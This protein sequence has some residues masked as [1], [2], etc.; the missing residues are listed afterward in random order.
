MEKVYEELDEVKAELEKLR[1]EYKSKSELYE[2][3]RKAHNEQL[4]KF[5]QASSKIE[6]QT[7]ELNKKT[8]EISMAQQTCEDLKCALKEEESIVQHLRAANDKLRVDCDEKFRKLEDTNKALALALDEANEKKMDQEQTLCAYKDEI[9]D[10]KGRLSVSQKKCSEA[11]KKAN[12]P[13]E[14]RERDE[15]ILKL[16]EE[17]HKVQD[18]IKWKTE[19][20][21]HLEEAHD[22]LRE[23]FKAGKKEWEME[24]SSFL[25]EI[26]Q[27]QMSLDSK[28]QISDNL[29]NRLQGCNQ[30][31]A[32]EESRTKYL[33]VQVSEFQTRFENVFSDRE[34]AKSQLECL[35]AQRD[36][37]IASLRQSLSTKEALHKEMGYQTRKLEQENQEL[38]ALLKE[39]Q[40]AQIQSAPGS[41][42]L[43]K[44][45]NK[46]KSLE[47][48]HRESVANHRAKEAEW[49]S[50]L[51]SMTAD[52][53]NHKSELKS[54][55][56]A[57]KELRMEVEQKHRDC[58][59]NRLNKV[60]CN[61]QLEKM[62]SDVRNYMNEL[63]RKDATIEELEMELE[64]NHFLSMQELSVML[65]VLKLGISGAQLKIANE[66]CEMDRHDKENE[67]KISLLMQQLEMK[68]DVLIRALAGTEEEHEKAASLSSRIE[69]M[70]LI[71]NQKLHIRKEVERELR[72]VN[73]ALERSNVELAE[74]I[75][76]ENEIEFELQIWK[77]I[78]ERLRSDLEAS[79]GMCKEL[80]ASLLAQVEVEETIK[81][82]KKG[83]L[84]IFE[85][86]DKIIDNLQ[87]KI[88]LLE[89]KLDDAE[90]VKTE[91][92]MSL[93]SENSIFLQFTREKDKNFEQLEK[94]VH[95]LE[96]ESLRREFAG[97]VMA[98]TDAERTFEYEK[99]KL[100]QHVEEKYQR[101]NVLLQ[102]V[103][104]LEHKFNSSLASF[105]SQLAEK[106]SEID[107]IYEAWEKITA[108]EVMAALEI[109]EKQLMAMELEDEICNIQQKLESQQ[110]SSCE[111]KQKALEVE[112]QLET[113]EQEVKRLTNQMKTK[114][115]NSDPLVEELKNKRRN[116]LEDVIQLSSEKENLLRFIGGLGD[117][118]W[119]FCATDKQLMGML[120][121]IM[122]S[123]DDKGSGMD[124]KWDD[125]LVDPEQEN[126]RT[127][128]I[129]KISEA[130]SDKR[131]P[132]RDLNH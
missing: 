88:V 131:S 60:V 85:E 30:A 56:A 48:M 66:K 23:Q 101:V 93:E 73:D 105:S 46:L 32:H 109:E 51:E 13:K 53:N 18:K 119:E 78:A 6:Q 125:E 15:V 80:E 95:W 111:S 41:P 97:L 106:Q 8:E 9:K 128:I 26:C 31:L 38:R 40:E 116:L 14:P 84:S 96:Q 86:K 20:F 43:A 91:T 127:P 90:S 110:K 98:Q 100:I 3:L 55:G 68:N 94:E 115:I 132:F 22:K 113:K 42:S 37:Q 34:H 129:V 107:M 59:D 5:Q 29:Q 58:T 120:E 25:D 81:Q 103:E 45:R 7:Q 76:E 75:F 126:V 4:T 35:T 123:F 50:Q 61:S 36:K 117:K 54:N 52:L 87:E 118:L 16:E 65:L 62:T 21:R 12:V 130:I 33:E 27:L 19:Q 69:V 67:E 64:S 17:N 79:V 102:L 57:L 49:S 108:A 74:K 92:S 2:S 124:L 10:L 89:Q 82:Q 122:L 114:L 70:D 83:L 72:E 24:K 11:E 121:R 99:E 39:L 28:T 63:E 104:S 77:S 112:A 47:Q 44:L 1:A 71:D